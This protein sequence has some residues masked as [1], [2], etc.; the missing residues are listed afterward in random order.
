LTGVADNNKI[1]RFM[2]QQLPDR[3]RLQPLTG[4]KAF[5]QGTLDPRRLQRIHEFGEVIAVRDIRLELSIETRE[6]GLFLLNGK[7]AARMELVCQRCLQGYS[8]SVDD[9]IRLNA[10]AEPPG[11]EGYESVDLEDDMLDVERL[12]EDELI[13]RIP[14]RP[15][16]ARIEDCD[17]NMLHRVKE[18][19]GEISEKRDANPFAV[20]KREEP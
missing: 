15:V 20:L 2:S 9:T 5:I 8:W 14:Q 12:V 7:I 19:D 4:K 10:G 18:Y 6:S 13:L 1:A 17:P 11:M 16:H 3:V